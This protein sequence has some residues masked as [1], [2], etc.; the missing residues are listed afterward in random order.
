MMDN[1]LRDTT[2]RMREYWFGLVVRP[3]DG[4]KILIPFLAGIVLGLR[5]EALSHLR[6]TIHVTLDISSTSIR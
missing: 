2:G 1:M 4:W 6:K 5:L 3:E